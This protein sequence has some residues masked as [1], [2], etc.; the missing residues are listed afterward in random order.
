MPENVLFTN[1]R[2][3]KLRGHLY[4]VIIMTHGFARDKTAEKIT[5]FSQDLNSIGFA[6]L[7]FDFSGCGESDNDTITVSKEIEDLHAAIRFVQSKG[8]SQI[9][10]YGH[11]LG[12][13]V[14]LSAYTPQVKTIAMTGGLTGPF[15]LRVA[16]TEAQLEDLKIKGTTIEP[17]T[18]GAYRSFVEVDQALISELEEA[19][20]EK[21]LRT[22][23]CPVLMIHG[24]RDD[25]EKNLYEISKTGKA[26]LP[27]SDSEIK[28]IPQATH[29]FEGFFDD[30]SDLLKEWFVQHMDVK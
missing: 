10:L 20:Q 3:K 25:V 29:S 30:V 18:Q 28:V 13:F 2:H 14:C 26:Y 24:Q 19:S 17:I 15:N 4:L 27:Q 21:L 7:A 5:K 1:T 6:V 12:G 11:S 23:K 8:Y 22:I 9:G 16:F